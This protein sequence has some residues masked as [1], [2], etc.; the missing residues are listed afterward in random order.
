MSKT[1]RPPTRLPHLTTLTPYQLAPVR[2]VPVRFVPDE[3]AYKLEKHLE[4][5]LRRLRC[6]ARGL[7]ATEFEKLIRDDKKCE[8]AQ[9]CNPSKHEYEKI[10]R[11][12]ARLIALRK[13]NSG[14][15]QLPKDIRDL[16]A[17]LADVSSPLSPGHW[18]GVSPIRFPGP[19][20][21]YRALDGVWFGCTA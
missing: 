21:A 20:D 13:A 7:D 6:N 9:A 8:I 11:R 17:P 10:R 18:S 3:P 2:F 14:T 15:A 4:I 12:V 1:K 16:L 5:F 19:A